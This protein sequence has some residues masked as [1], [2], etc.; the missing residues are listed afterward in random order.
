MPQRPLPNPYLEPVLDVMPQELRRQVAEAAKQAADN[1]E[2]PELVV[3]GLRYALTR[4]AAAH[5]VHLAPHAPVSAEAVGEAWEEVKDIVFSQGR[6]SATERECELCE[7][8]VRAAQ[9]QRR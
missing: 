8:W 2:I 9:E 1:G 5:A 3:G 4:M 7:R 6:T